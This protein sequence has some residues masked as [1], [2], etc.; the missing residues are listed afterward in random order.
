MALAISYTDTPTWCLFWG[1]TVVV[2]SFTPPAYLPL[3]CPLPLWTPY[4]YYTT[5][6][7]KSYLTCYCLLT[8]KPLCCSNVISVVLYSFMSLYYPHI[9]SF[10]TKTLPI[11]Q[12]YLSFIPMVSHN[13]TTCLTY[14]VSCDVAGLVVWSTQ[15]VNPPLYC[16]RSR[17]KAALYHVMIL[18]Q[19]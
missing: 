7:Q 10:I 9:L 12:F 15:P 5:H 2:K 19:F 3:H 1:P 6:W 17:P 14:S 16:G 13:L 4:L 11:S 8:F 18:E